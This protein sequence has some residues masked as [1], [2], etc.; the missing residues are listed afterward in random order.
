MLERFLPPVDQNAVDERIAAY[1]RKLLAGFQQSSQAKTK[2]WKSIFKAIDDASKGE[3]NKWFR[4]LIADIDSDKVNAAADAESEKVFKK[5]EQ[6]SALFIRN[7]QQFSKRM[8]N[9]R[10]AV[11]ERVRNAIR[12][13][14]NVN[15]IMLYLFSMNYLLFF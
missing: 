8:N 13:L 7:I 11:R 14:P 5:L 10:E 2:L 15:F 6:S 3:D 12:H 1:V 4:T 9:R